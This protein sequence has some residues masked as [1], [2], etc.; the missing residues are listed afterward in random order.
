MTRPDPLNIALTRQ[1]SGIAPQSL[2]KILEVFDATPEIARVWLYG[3]RARGDHRTASDIDF[4]IE[5]PEVDSWVPGL[6][7]RIE[8]L[9]L[10]YKIEL[11]YDRPSL[12][13]RF[14]AITNLERRLF[15]EPRRP[16]A[17][18]ET[19]ATQLKPFQATVLSRLDVY[20]AELKKHRAQS[21]AAVNALQGMEG[22]EHLLREAADFPKKAWE[23]LKKAE[24]LPPAFAAR[25]HSSRFDGAGRAIPNICLKVPTGGG[26]TLLAAA[27]VARVC[28]AFLQR[29]AG[30]VL[31]IVPNEAIYRQTLKTLSDRDHPYRQM[32]NV[33][34][35]G[36]VKILEKDAP[37]TRLDVES[38][39]CVML[40]MLQSAARRD[41]AQKKLKAFRDRGNVLGFTPRE[42]D[43][44]GHWRLLEAVPNLDVY[45][46]HGLSPEAARMQKGSIVKDS[47]GNVLRL[48]QPVV[49]MDE[50]HHAYTENALRTLDGFNPAFL[51]ELSATPR[52]ASE[53]NSG[54]NILVDVRGTDLDEA[55]MI[56]LPIHVDVRAWP[57]WQSCLASGVE[58]LNTLAREAEM[59]RAETNR[60]IRPLLLVQ[61]ERTGRDLRDA[62]FIHAEDA[63]AYLM[64]LGLAERQ[65]AIK[66]SDKDELKQPE[67]ID[68]LSPACEVRAIITKQA[69][70]EGW[71]CPF[72]YVLCALAAGREVRAMTQLT[73]RILR[74]P[75]V[76]K[77]GRPALDSC[78]VLCHDAKT[79]QVVKAI[80]DSLET[81]GMGDLTLSVSGGSAPET[82]AQVFA[83]RPAFSR[84]RVFLPR[85]TWV[86]QNGERRE[87]AYESDV[88]AGIDWAELG[89]ESLGKDWAPSGPGVAQRF[90]VG[91]EVLEHPER[92]SAATSL[93]RPERL[94]RA[95]LVRGLL[96]IAPNPW[97][98]WQ[99]TDA[100]ITRLLA[101]G[102]T[103]S[104]LA[105][106]VNALLE[107]LRTDLEA[108]RDRLA[109][110]VFDNAV[111]AGRIEFRLRADAADYELPSEF[112][113]PLSGRP[114]LLT[115][116]DG[117]PVEKSLFE[118]ALAALV[119]SGLERDV[120]CYLDS[121]AALIWWHRNVAKAQ[122]G[123]QGWK[124]HKVY[125]DF[126][127]ARLD[128]DGGTRTVV[129]ETK[130]LHLAGSDDTA[131]KQR[132]LERLSQAFRDERTLRAGELELSGGDSVRLCCDLLFDA[133]WQ[134]R[135]AARHFSA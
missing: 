17:M 94:D 133:A 81:E 122:Y 97:W 73:G 135:L 83:R 108:E 117:L 44:D 111:A 61:V 53:K 66:T 28:S 67:N 5:A 46:P 88:L 63:K 134:G 60:Y 89:V 116:E 91:L 79:G 123:L 85:V 112:R 49:V 24:A 58:C 100:V 50:G 77:T 68:L 18:E 99:W 120:A 15:W 102:V 31:W 41:E 78:Y 34:G 32:L 92:V 19:G 39:L 16:A 14:R 6:S 35:A 103:E 47:L 21:E 25:P 69:L 106:A 12:D 33:A 4:L 52:V 36:R 59:L 107:R 3:S 55:E 74:Q 129:L 72:A 43:Y 7:R 93:L 131:Y 80:K 114:Q 37:L 48:M 51:L 101:R 42:D 125:P 30:L 105:A 2:S 132:L 124:R 86:E 54:S 1:D 90:D 95:L 9:G 84:L 96:D 57:D 104:S 113:L 23:A 109:Q 121:Q 38:N 65:I 128:G 11:T 27:G 115:R 22:M 70:Q 29:H 26:K 10:L 98:L 56:K 127:F 76:A 75:Q 40:L 8:E 71:D 45:A 13:E 20:L 82:R 110:G 64:Q 130:G 118:P 119:D 87:L 62:G 126:V